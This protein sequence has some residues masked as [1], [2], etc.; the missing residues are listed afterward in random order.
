MEDLREDDLKFNQRMLEKGLFGKKRKF[1]DE[2]EDD[3][4]NVVKRTLEEKEEFMR[5]K[6]AALYGDPEAKACYEEQRKQEERRRLAEEEKLDED[7]IERHLKEMDYEKFQREFN[8]MDRFKQENL[9]KQK[10]VQKLEQTELSKVIDLS[11]RIVKPQV[12]EASLSTKDNSKEKVKFSLKQPAGS[13]R[14]MMLKKGLETDTAI[15]K[16]Q[17]VHE[18]GMGALFKKKK[19]LA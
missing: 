6:E 3:E 10:E 9:K 19:G 2:E 13:I 4:N 16:S 1:H 12:S 8:N 11:K 18:S 5:M 15:R 14:N 17:N 7:E